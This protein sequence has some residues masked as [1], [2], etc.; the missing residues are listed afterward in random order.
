MSNVIIDL[1]LSSDEETPQTHPIVY[2]HEN[3]RDLMAYLDTIYRS[4]RR[5]RCPQC[6]L[7]IPRGKGDAT[8]ADVRIRRCQASCRNCQ[9]SWC[10]ACASESCLVRTPDDS[11]LFPSGACPIIRAWALKILLPVID[12]IY[13]SAVEEDKVKATEPK[14]VWTCPICRL[15]QDDDVKACSGCQFENVVD[16]SWKCPSCTLVNAVDEPGCSA[17]GY[18]NGANG[19]SHLS[20]H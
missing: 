20:L 6:N 4:L 16:G 5:L 9:K 11:A 15:I 17:C 3:P 14:G 2:V 10:L 8:Q 1:T 18:A 12:I 19:N 7:D 13:E